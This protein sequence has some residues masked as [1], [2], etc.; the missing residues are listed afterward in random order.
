MGLIVSGLM[1]LIQCGQ[2]SD[3]LDGAR[4]SQGG[5]YSDKD[6]DDASDVMLLS[7]YFGF[8]V[9]FQAIYTQMSTTF[10]M[11]GCQ[12]DLRM[13]SGMISSS[14]LNL[15]DCVVILLFIPIFDS[16]I[17]PM[18]ARAGYSPTPLK[19][20]GAGYVFAMAAMFMAA[21]IET[22]RKSVG[23]LDMKSNCGDMGMSNMSVWL[24]IPQYVLV[25]IAEILI[26]IAG[27]DLFYTQAPESMQSVCQSINLL[28]QTAGGML[29]AGLLVLMGGWYTDDL[30]DGHLE[31]IY[32][33]Y[34]L[35][36]AVNLAWYF[37]VSSSFVYKEDR[38]YN[39]GH[40][41]ETLGE[42]APL[43]LRA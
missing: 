37:K 27:M 9:M 8:M 15:F 41:P 28:T 24:Q 31:Y 6:V 39:R 21:V 11:Q 35:L 33:V 12:M 1:L 34:C 18:C 40:R 17:Y 26:N 14:Q 42:N 19:K 16:Y 23:I 29:S 4:I 30:D 32:Y 38:V 5:C 25:G 3:W 7:P 10:V 22:E 36:I 20:I 2:K 43:V 13:G